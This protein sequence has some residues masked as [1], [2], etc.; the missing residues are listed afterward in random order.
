[1]SKLNTELSIDLKENRSWK[2]FLKAVIVLLIDSSSLKNL[3]TFELV[4]AHSTASFINNRSIDSRNLAESISLSIRYEDSSYFNF[5]SHLAVEMLFFLVNWSQKLNVKS[6]DTVIV[7]EIS[8]MIRIR[9][10][11][12]SKYFS[13]SD[14]WCNTLWWDRPYHPG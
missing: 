11:E 10:R 9:V 1:M 14:D 13:M 7:I 6:R 2:M 8:K 3:T 5:F 12:F 4:S